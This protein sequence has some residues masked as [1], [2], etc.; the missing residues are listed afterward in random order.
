MTREII[1]ADAVRVSLNAE[2]AGA[3]VTALLLASWSAL[4]IGDMAKY[5]LY[6]AMYQTLT[7]PLLV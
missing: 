6:T 3:L 5:E 7:R 2:E 4:A 1:N